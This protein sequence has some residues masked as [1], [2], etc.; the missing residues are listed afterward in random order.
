MQIQIAGF[1]LV[2][3][4]IAAV[5]TLSTVIAFARVLIRLSLNDIS[6]WIANGTIVLI[7]G[8]IVGQDI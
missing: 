4:S 8:T 7:L 6:T 3:C 1:R 2:A 5:E